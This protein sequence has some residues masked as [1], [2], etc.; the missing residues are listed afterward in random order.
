M[1]PC[2]RNVAASSISAIPASTHSPVLTCPPVT[3]EY[4]PILFRLFAPADRVLDT[5]ASTATG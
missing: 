3:D 1:R 5:I 2:F 4:T